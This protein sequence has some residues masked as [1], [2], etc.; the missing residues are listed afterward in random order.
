VDLL[1]FTRQYAGPISHGTSLDIVLRELN[2]NLKDSYGS[3]W[4]NDIKIVG[5]DRI[6]DE[7]NCYIL[8]YKY[9]SFKLHSIFIYKYNGKYYLQEHSFMT[10]H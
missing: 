2:E 4:F 3:D 1:L 5:I 9:G 7:K 10:I 8:K 6:E